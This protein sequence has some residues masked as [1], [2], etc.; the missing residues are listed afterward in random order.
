MDIL[1]AGCDVAGCGEGMSKEGEGGRGK[2]LMKENQGC[3][4]VLLFPLISIPPHLKPCRKDKISL[5]TH[6]GTFFGIGVRFHKP[7]SLT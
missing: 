6:D 1:T 4:S 2:Q 7:A 5:K 3:G